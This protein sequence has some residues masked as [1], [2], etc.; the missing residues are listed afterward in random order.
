MT[1]LFV[2][3][4]LF[5]LIG[6]PV[7]FS[8][9]LSVLVYIVFESTF[10]ISIILQRMIAGVDSFPL[11][12][13][14]LFVFAGVLMEKGS[15]KRLT[16]FADSLIGFVKGGFGVVTVAA[17][18]F[19][20]AVSGSG[21]AT[22]AAIGSIMGPEMVKR[23]YAK[24]FTAS[25]IASSGGLGIL[26][27][28]SLVMVIFGVS[29]GVS[30]GSLLLA[31]VIPGII[32]A[33]LLAIT[34]IIMAKKLGYEKSGSFELRE[35]LESFKGAI[36]PL[37]T[38]IIIMGGIILGIF[39]PTEAAAVG[40]IYAFILAFFVYKELKIRDFPIV[41]KKV[42]AS[43]VM[44]LFIIAVSSPFGWII[45]SEQIPQKISEALLSMFSSPIMIIIVIQ[46]IILI[47]GMFMETNAIVLLT[48]P[49]FFPIA[50][51]LGMDPLVYAVVTLINLIIG[52]AT[53]PLAVGLFIATSI[54]KIEIH[55][56]F[57]YL[58]P[59]ILAL[60]VSVGIHILFPSLTTFL[61]DLL[62]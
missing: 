1:L 56:T 34:A 50:V 54:L 2:S 18:A 27:P 13:L 11:L 9:G 43:S 52:G 51:G 8:I 5:I 4:L 6:V 17:S 45:S 59:F 25:V 26:I 49:I 37:L 24:G 15:T 7:A 41:L 16:R 48:T 57:K 55:E 12:A 53:P 29:S 22:V 46:L 36:L 38:P 19:F 20:G 32:T 40:T 14:P 47:L 33:V 35:V 61:P 39:T 58:W 3:L 31:G 62:M 44:I 23:N 42:V 10:P 30:I 21:A 28:P 60:L